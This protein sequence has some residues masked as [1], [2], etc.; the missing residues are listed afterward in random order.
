MERHTRPRRAGTQAGTQY[1]RSTRPY[2]C[3][4]RLDA[5]RGVNRLPGGGIDTAARTSRTYKPRLTRSPPPSTRTDV[6][7]APDVVV[8]LGP[9][10]ARRSIR[11]LGLLD[12]L[13]R[14]SAAPPSAS[15]TR[16]PTR[17]RRFPSTSSANL[18]PGLPR[19]APAAPTGR[20]TPLSLTLS[21]ILV[22]SRS[23]TGGP[24]GLRPGD[25]ALVR[26]LLEGGWRPGRRCFCGWWQVA[27]AFDIDGDGHEYVLQVGLRPASVAAVAHAVPSENSPG[28][29]GA[30]VFTRGG[31]RL[32]TGWLG[33][34]A[35]IRR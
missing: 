18:M 17:T 34:Y 2:S 31:D 19:S 16:T 15:R 35:A 26:K 12:A 14:S 24:P 20:R 33:A 28:N 27:E 7:T 3:S 13:A 22:W 5:G 11:A 25:A 8:I 10:S 1:D 29:S 6:S 30:A 4:P 9:R 23:V 21:G 32:G